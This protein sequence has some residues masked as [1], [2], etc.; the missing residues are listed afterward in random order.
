MT[1]TNQKNHS[2]YNK[3]FIA[4]TFM[5]QIRKAPYET[6]FW[7]HFRPFW[8]ENPQKKVIFKKLWLLLLNLDD[9]LTSFNKS[10][11]LHEQ[12]RGKPSEK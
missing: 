3:N 7:S 10:E 1:N 11:N 8:S 2:N 6:L 12:F 4:I 5:L 9:P